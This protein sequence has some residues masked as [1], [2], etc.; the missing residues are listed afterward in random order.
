MRLQADAP[1]S[2]VR[3]TEADSWTQ[4]TAQRDKG[5]ET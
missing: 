5:G 4:Q 3:E 2:A 1:A